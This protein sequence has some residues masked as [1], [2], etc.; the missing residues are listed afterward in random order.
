M[1]FEIFSFLKKI[2]SGKDG[3]I[4]L[5]DALHSLAE[6][7]S[8]CLE[9]SLSQSNIFD[10]G[11]KKGFIGANIAIASRDKDIIKY[12]KEIIST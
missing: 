6:K 4:Q 1:P 10:C 9:A 11:S 7:N 5:T 12:L 8:E 3:E 2:T